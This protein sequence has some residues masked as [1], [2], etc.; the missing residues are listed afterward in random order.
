MENSLPK[1]A[2]RPKYI[3]LYILF[4]VPLTGVGIDLYA[5][6][7][8]WIVKA[9]HTTP[10]LVKLTIAMYLFGYSIGPLFAGTFSDTYGRKPIIRFGMVFYIL[11]CISIIL[12]QNIYV[13]LSMRFLQGVGASF[14]AV[15]YRAMLTDSYD[16]GKDIQTMGAQ[17]AL[18]WSI[19]P[20][21]A[22]FIGGYLQHYFNWEAN[23]IFYIGYAACVFVGSLF[24]PET[25]THKNPWDPSRLFCQYREIIKHK[26]F[27]S[28][29]ICMAGV[30]AMI[31][32]FNIVG[33]FL[34][35]NI[36]HFTA[37]QFG[38]VA[39]IV[40]FGSLIGNI[41]NRLLVGR[42][43]IK[44]LIQF[45]ILGTLTSFIVLLV[46]GYTLPVNLYAYMIPIFFGILFTS[47]VFPNSMATV[48]SLFPKMAGAAGAMVGLT[49]SG[50]TAFAAVAASHLMSATQVPV[51][52]AYIATAL[53][54]ALSYYAL[55]HRYLCSKK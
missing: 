41:A 11:V 29:V 20:I 37:V 38:Y 6:S 55:M 8:P 19:G 24:L 21:V 14:I 25:N 50:L 15:A 47:F 39:L 53:V 12:F 17:V 13:M 35:Q 23:F 1:A 45:G 30:Y 22:P 10:S 44:K 43:H 26:L 18:T 7:L 36:L 27:W 2:S 51:G 42:F 32:Y 49:F 9:L 34:V 48:L 16:R 4:I 52:Y 33:P 28:S 40:G 46:L 31:V 54:M 5:P 3:T